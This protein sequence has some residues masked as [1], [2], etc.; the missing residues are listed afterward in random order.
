MNA[1]TIV[2]YL[3]AVSNSNYLVNFSMHIIVLLALTTIFLVKNEQLKRYVFH[4]AIS[5]LLLSVTVNALVYGNPF[6]VITFAIVFANLKLS[7]LTSNC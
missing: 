6:H 4:A 1:Q 3:I 5:I 2:N 7:H